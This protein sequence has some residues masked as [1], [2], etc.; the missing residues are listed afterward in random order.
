M[1]NLRIRG[2]STRRRGLSIVE[3]ALA[4]PIFLLLIF[5]I[6][7]I[8]RVLFAHMTLQHAVREAGRF[9]VTGRTSPGTGGS[10][11]RLDSI[12]QIVVDDSVP[13]PLTT[14]DVHVSSAGGG[15]GSAGGPGD[16]VTIEVLYRVHLLTPLI[17]AFFPPDGT[18][19]VDVSTTFRNEPFPGAGN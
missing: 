1:E 18:F 2:R 15:S 16:R 13:F 3:T 12:V 7:D 11:P 8:G 6:V 17:G 5:G 4:L 10:H 19:A 9:A 14:S